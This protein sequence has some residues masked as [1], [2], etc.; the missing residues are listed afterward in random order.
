MNR[1]FI[2]FTSYEYHSPDNHSH[3]FVCTEHKTINLNT[4]SKASR[5]RAERLVR[6]AS[7]LGLAVSLTISDNS[8]WVCIFNEA[9]A[10]QEA[11]ARLEEYLRG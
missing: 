1:L 8:M 9:Q 10:E 3:A 7:S 5:K 11:A 2:D 4:I 6:N